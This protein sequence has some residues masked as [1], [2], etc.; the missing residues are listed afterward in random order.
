MESNLFFLHYVNSS[1][2]EWLK[3]VPWAFRRLLVWIKD[4]YG[5][6]PIMVTENGVSDRN[7][8]LTDDHR[9]S[10]YKQYINEMLKGKFNFVLRVFKTFVI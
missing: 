10:Y 7:G 1:G 5:N 9:I 3:V 8:S 4:H 2:S 6:V